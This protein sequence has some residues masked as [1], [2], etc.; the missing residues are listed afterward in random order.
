MAH[1][2][3]TLHNHFDA[4]RALTKF[5]ENR[6]DPAGGGNTWG[7]NDFISWDGLEAA[8]FARNGTLNISTFQL[9]LAH[10]QVF[11]AFG[12]RAPSR[13]AGR[14]RGEPAADEPDRL[15]A[16]QSHLVRIPYG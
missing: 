12:A 11:Q 14:S 3:I 10:T 8:G 9:K 15:V 2:S 13:T 7:W 5:G 6:Y 1:F 4:S 16:S